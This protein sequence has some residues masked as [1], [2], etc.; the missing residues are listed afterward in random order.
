MSAVLICSID[1]VRRHFITVL[2]QQDRDR[3]VLDSRIHRPA[4][5]FLDLLRAG[6]RCDI[7]VLRSPGQDRIA[8]AAPH[9]IRLVAVELQIINYHQHFSG[10]LYLHLKLLFPKFIFHQLP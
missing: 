9:R 10:Q 3:T 4:E 6:G 8:H 5:Q 1:P 2:S 7:P